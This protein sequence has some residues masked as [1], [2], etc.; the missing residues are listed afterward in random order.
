MSLSPSNLGLLFATNLIKNL[1]DVVLTPADI[2]RFETRHS[3]ADQLF[4]RKALVHQNSFIGEIY[5]QSIYE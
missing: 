1:L 3:F 2:C 5:Y 4:K